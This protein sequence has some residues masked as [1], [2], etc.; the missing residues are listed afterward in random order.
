[1]ETT[2]GVGPN[3]G[4]RLFELLK[5]LIQMRRLDVEVVTREV[6]LNDEMLER[7]GRIPS[8]VRGVRLRRAS[9]HGLMQTNH[10]S[11]SVHLGCT[12]VSLRISALRAGVSRTGESRRS[13]AVSMKRQRATPMSSTTAAA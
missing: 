7:L 8:S 5:I 1:M 6:G 2:A 4:L 12:V 9:T 3:A 10:A 11:K 13:A